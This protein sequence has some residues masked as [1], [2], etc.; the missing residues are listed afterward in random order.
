MFYLDGYDIYHSFSNLNTRFENLLDDPLFVLKFKSF[1]LPFIIKKEFA[2]SKSNRT[3]G[4][5]E[6]CIC[7]QKVY[8][9]DI[10]ENDH[11]AFYG[12]NFL[13]EKQ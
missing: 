13:I 9:N 4:L 8:M 7:K 6:K 12:S 5:G 3:E 1:P 11:Y 10:G 2:F